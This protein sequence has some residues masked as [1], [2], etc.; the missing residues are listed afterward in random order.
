MHPA[1]QLLRHEGQQEGQQAAP[2]WTAED[3]AALVVQQ[4]EVA[5]L[6]EG[7][8]QLAEELVIQRQRADRTVRQAARQEAVLFEQGP[9]APPEEVQVTAVEIV[10]RAA[11]RAVAVLEDGTA[12]E[13]ALHLLGL[14]VQA[15]AAARSLE[16]QV[17]RGGLPAV[18]VEDGAIFELQAAAQRFG[19]PGHTGLG[20]G[21]L[22]RSQV[23]GHQ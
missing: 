15:A 2:V 23:T 1:L 18:L 3:G 19:R 9:V 14:D 17:D 10:Q 12:A 8:Q 13:L 20:E 22:Q 4:H 6:L 7:K 21:V 5:A 16:R 11:P